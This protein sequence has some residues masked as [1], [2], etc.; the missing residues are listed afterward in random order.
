[1]Y[2]LTIQIVRFVDGSFPGWAACELVDAYGRKHNIRGKAP[3][4]TVENM[5]AH[6]KYPVEGTLACEVLDRY[7]TEGIVKIRTAKPSD[8]ESAE[9]LTEFLVPASSLTKVDA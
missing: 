1:M 3:I 2:N 8:V 5:D 7:P 4:F 9:G 6:N